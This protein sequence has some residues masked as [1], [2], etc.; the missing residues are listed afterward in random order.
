MAISDH[1]KQTF[2][3][4]LQAFNNQALHLIQGTDTHS[5]EEVTCVCM[6]ISK[7]G[8]LPKGPEEILCIPLARLFKG[9]PGADVTLPELTATPAN[10]ENKGN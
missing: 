1:D 8:K 10:P 9:D 6:T 4:M 7:T 5:G 2:C 3:M